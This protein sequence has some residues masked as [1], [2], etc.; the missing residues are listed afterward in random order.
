MRRSKAQDEANRYKWDLTIALAEQ[1][2]AKWI[3]IEGYRVAGIETIVPTD[4]AGTARM[5]AQLLREAHEEINRL[6][7]QAR[8]EVR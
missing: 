8:P 3:L 1:E 5:A 6:R 2:R 7:A 4:L